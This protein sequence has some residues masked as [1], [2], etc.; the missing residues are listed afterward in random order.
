MAGQLQLGLGRTR[1]LGLL[2]DLLHLG[3][4]ALHVLLL[5]L[6][7]P[8]PLPPGL[9]IVS[10]LA[11]VLAHLHAHLH[12]WLLDAEGDRPQSDAAGHLPE[13]KVQQKR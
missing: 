11:H 3:F 12:G 6:V 5:L 4:D 1:Q 8:L 10:H 2:E 13:Q 7:A 9:G